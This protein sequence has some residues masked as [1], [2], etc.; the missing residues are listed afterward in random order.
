MLLALA[1]ACKPPVEAPAEIGELTLYMYENFDGTGEDGA[2]AL[3]AGLLQLDGWLDTMP[4]SLEDSVDDRAVTPPKLPESR[5]GGAD[6][7]SSFSEELQVPVAVVAEIDQDM[8]T[9]LPVMLDAN[10]V[11]IASGTTTWH[12]Q[13][14][15]S[16][17]ACFTDGSCPTLNTSHEIHIDSLNNVWIDMTRDYTW[18]ELED[19]RMAVVA[20]A[21]TSSQS[22][23]YDGDGTWDQRYD[24]MV[25]LPTADGAGLR[26]FYSMWSSVTLTGVG[27]DFYATTVKN[28][29]DEHY[30]NTVTFANGESCD[31]RD[32]AYTRD[33]DEG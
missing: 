11:C 29:L 3:P 2:D 15:D 32:N 20:R 18:V 26:R 19:G 16:D 21:W 13:T 27:D 9:Q 30:N 17:E 33:D 10:Q 12:A 1:L 28:G 25:W 22:N 14:F 7:P 6:V 24:L 4:L 8:D 31:D 5:L 23:A